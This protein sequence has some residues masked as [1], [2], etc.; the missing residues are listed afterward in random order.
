M[1][2]KPVVL[3]LGAAGFV[4]SALADALMAA[5]DTVISVTRDRT[6]VPPGTV[7]VHGDVTNQDFCRRVIADYEVDVIYHL[8]A[9]SIVSVCADDP[10]NA[11]KIAVLGT[12]RVL[13]A[14]RD[15]ERSVCAVVM[16]SDKAYGHAPSPYT[17]ETPF[18]ARYAYEVSKACQDIV[19]R[20]YHHNFDL[21][22]RIV[23]AVNI[24]GPGDPNTSRLI[25]QTALRLLR[26]DPPLLHEG[27]ATMRRQYTYIDDVVSALR[28]VA[29]SGMAGEAYCLG[30][31]D[32]PMA[33]IEVMRV[34]A[35][36]AGVP[37]TAPVKRAREM[38]FQE[39]A[40][41]AVDDTK[42]RGLGWT[43]VVP[44]V[45]GIRRTLD[46]YGR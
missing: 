15:T 20:M 25:P 40:S 23:R 17:E 18:D 29:D 33:V 5:G 43:P 21:D 32:A 16:T 35:E 26:G 3:V 44:F 22:V 27:A 30:S 36:V 14:V 2:H 38:R 45:E 46:W 41:Q 11:L 4:G 28:V 7:V 9:Q 6:R 13:Q 37:F 12:A 8:A 19:A 24:Y 39:I 10:I 34:M 31:P 42:L 1:A